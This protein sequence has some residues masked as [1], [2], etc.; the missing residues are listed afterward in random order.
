VPVVVGGL[1]VVVRLAECVANGSHVRRAWYALGDSWY[2]LGPALVL[3]I[4]AGGAFSFTDWPVY[5]V[6]LAAQFGFDAAA[7]CARGWFSERIPPA[8]QLSLCAWIWVVDTELAAVGLLLAAVSVDRPAMVL[9]AL[10]VAHLLSLFALERSERLE[11][12]RALASAY[13]GTALLLGDV[14]E[15]DDAYTGSHSR[16]VLELALGVA[17]ALGLDPRA[18][19][20]VEFGALL[21]DVGKMRVPKEILHKPGPLNDAEWAV[22]RRHT[23]EGESMLQRVGGALSD[24]GRVVRSS[25]E[26]Y[27]GNGYPDGLAGEAIPLEARIVSACDAF[28]AM[29]TDR[30]YRRARSAVEALREMERCA[31][32]QFDPGVVSALC[33]LVREDRGFEPEG[34]GAALAGSLDPRGLLVEPDRA[35]STP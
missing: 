32:T 21:H 31:G 9:I 2:A 24:V 28:S 25:H 33:A 26:H 7:T 15:A 10:P 22:I 1:A 4:G 5:V 35:R 11:Q 34:G 27:D 14:V 8:V 30:S 20:N 13:R 29:T 23:I 17:D 6:A 18:R 3:T 19:R 16:G 12:S